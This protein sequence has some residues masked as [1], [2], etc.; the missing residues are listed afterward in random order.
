MIRDYIIFA[1]CSLSGYSCTTFRGS[2]S[3]HR[4]HVSGLVVCDPRR[5]A[6]LQ[7]GKNDRIDA[8]K[9]AELLYQKN[10]TR[11]IVNWDQPSA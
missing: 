2:L 7:D 9:L 3:S 5:N 4:P 8:R 10:S 1:F 11:V 6:L